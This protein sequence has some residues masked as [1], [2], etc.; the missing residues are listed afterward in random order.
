MGGA[1]V[2]ILFLVLSVSSMVLQNGLFNAVSKKQLHNRTDNLYYSS[3][4]YLIA[5]PLFLIPAIGS[6]LSL[7]TVLLGAAF[8]VLTL[9]TNF[10][11]LTALSRGP[12]HMTV[13]LVTASM[14]IPTMSG[15]L[16]WQERFSVGK[17]ISMLG[18]LLCIWVSLGRDGKTARRAGWLPLCICA[19]LG[20][21]SIGVMQKL[22][23]T[24]AHRDELY[25]F[26]AISFLCSF[27][28]SFALTRGQE[29]TVRFGRWDY[30]LAAVSGICTF[31]MNI[32]NLRLSGILPSQLFFPL[33][34]GSSVILSGIVSATLFREKITLRQGL[35][36]AGGLVCLCLI[37]IL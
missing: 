18:L 20:E 3:L 2:N 35:G 9:L 14:V 19:F 23:Q 16:F 26:L 22:H 4:L 24:S 10:L 7:Y 6:E 34:N 12:M 21:G 17:A 29:R 31:A 33:I 11:K 1:F 25:W 5:F 36:M 30:L 8:G 37:C 13:M 28:L 27:L 32:L 15:V